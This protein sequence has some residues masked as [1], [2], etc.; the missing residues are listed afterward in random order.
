MFNSDYVPNLHCFQAI[1]IRRHI[2]SFDLEN[3]TEGQI[4]S[5]QYEANV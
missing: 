1:A 3:C 2:L 4:Q 5:D